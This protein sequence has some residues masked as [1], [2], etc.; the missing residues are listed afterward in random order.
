MSLSLIKSIQKKGTDLRLILPFGLDLRIGD[1]ISVGKDGQFI[2]EGS[3]ATLLGIARPT[4]A[5]IR[6]TKIP[7]ADFVA[8]GGKGTSINFRPAG[9]ASTLFPKIPVGNAGFDIFFASANGWVLAFTGRSLS[10]AA[11]NPFRQPI[12]DA[13]KRGI[14]KPDWALVH[15]VSVV[16]RMTLVASEST[17][18]KVAISL[19]GTVPIHMP[20]VLQ[21]TA[22]ASF[23]HSNNA[24]VKW[25]SADPM[26]AFCSALRV[27]KS[28]FTTT[29]GALSTRE[30]KRLSNIDAA[31]DKTVW[32]NVDVLGP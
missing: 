10:T 25:A 24:F 9:K 20:L 29:T 32:E 12:L 1:V 2:L 11:A 30:N 17:N 22:D 23:D 26:T 5:A 31:S 27:K 19:G 4:G 21:L 16:Q 18:T 7:T 13:Y 15:S 6:S 28:W 3:T 8:Q 14:W